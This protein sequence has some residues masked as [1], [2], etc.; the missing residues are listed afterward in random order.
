MDRC[1]MLNISGDI[2][3]VARSDIRFLI[4]DSECEMSRDKLP[5]LLVWVGVPRELRTFV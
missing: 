3:A 4:A 1:R 5:C 2:P